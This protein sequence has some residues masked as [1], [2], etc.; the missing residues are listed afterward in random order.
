M[1]LAR[2][3]HAWRGRV[4]ASP[5]QSLGSK[6]VTRTQQEAGHRKETWH[7]GQPR[8]GPQCAV[9]EIPT[10]GVPRR[11]GGHNSQGWNCQ[12]IVVSLPS[13]LTFMPAFSHS[14]LDRAPSWFGIPQLHREKLDDN[15]R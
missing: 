2:L 11:A 4:L 3:A 13:A 12:L 1:M 8:K 14:P 9:E 10:W 6:E 15:R 5:E 7:R